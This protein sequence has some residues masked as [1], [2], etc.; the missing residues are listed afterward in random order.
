MRIFVTGGRGFIGR[1]ICEYFG[2]EHEIFAPRHQELELLD[3]DAVGGYIDRNDIEVVIHCANKGGSRGAVGAGKVV[4]D[5]L[6]MFFNIVRNC[7]TLDRVIYF[8]SGAEFDKSRDLKKIKEEQFGEKIPKDEYGFYKYVCNQYA[9]KSENVLN[10]RL[11][12]IFGK[13]ENY[14][15]R[16]ISN[17]IVK[18]L[19]GLDIT[20]NQNVVFDYLYIT[21]LMKTV[22]YFLKHKPKFHAYN[23][24]PN[25]SIDLLK[26]CEIVNK[27]SKN[28]SKIKV[29]T[30]GLNNE[31]TASNSRLR[32]EYSG[33]VFTNYEDA[34]KD[35]SSFY[36]A[37]LPT[38]NKENIVSDRYLVYC[39]SKT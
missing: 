13:Y 34:I 11:F 30:E 29:L 23:V 15:Y 31:Y 12:G 10:L 8:G 28:K 17:A 20:I 7:S 39:K 14:E 27:I 38:I 3:T 24:T 35:L 33:M 16:F 4:E 9:E 36:S 6:K 26:I 22:D 37:S 25:N 5:N 18:N 21:D 2:E 19:L 1:N 32:G